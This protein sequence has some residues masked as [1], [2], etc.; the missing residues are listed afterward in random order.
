IGVYAQDQIKLDNWIVTLGG[1]HDWAH[2]ET[3]GTQFNFVTSDLD[4]LHVSID[5]QAWTGFAGLSY[6]FANGLAPY[7]SYSTSFQPASGLTLVDAFGHPL[8]PTTGE[9]VEAGVKYQPPGSK[10]MLSA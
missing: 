3:S 6:V 4:P 2:T 8:K 9:G 5:D 10:T 7:V 1:R